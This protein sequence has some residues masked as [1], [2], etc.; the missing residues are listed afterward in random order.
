MSKVE[1]SIEDRE[2]LV[3]Y[4][5]SALSTLAVLVVPVLALWASFA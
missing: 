3:E 5:K 4:I 2:T 1:I